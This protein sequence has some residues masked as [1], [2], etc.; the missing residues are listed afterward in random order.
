[1]FA[2]FFSGGSAV[3]AQTNISNYS[4]S[5]ATGTTYTP[6]TGGT[7]AFS[8]AYDNSVSAA[9]TM[10]GTFPFGG[11]N[12]TTC[13]ISTN[14]FI[15]FGAAAGTTNYTPMSTLGTTTGAIAAFAQDAAAST[16]V[17]AVP[18]I[19]Y[20]NTGT[21]FV[22]QFADHANYYNRTT[23]RLNFQIR[24][25]YATGA[26][27][28]VYGTC[29][30]PGTVST[31][32]TAPQVGIR[33]NSVAYATNVNS[34]YIGNVPAST[35]CD[36]SNAVSGFANSSA[37][38][39]SGTTN[40]NVKI[41]AGLKYTWTPA[42]QLPVRTFTA[43]TAIT[44]AG[45]TL[46]WTAPT[47]A[48]S[49]N[50]QYR[51]P[52]T[53]SW[54]S[55]SGN[56][57]TTNSVTL[58][59]LTQT[60]SYQVRVQASNG[61]SQ[62][63][64]SH[65]PNSAGTGDGYSATGTF[66]TT[67]PTPPSCIALPTS[68]ANAA[69]GIATKVLTWPAAS[70]GAAGY[71]LY[72]GTDASATNIYNGV[73]LG[74][75][76]TYTIPATLTVGTYYWKIVPYNVYGSSTGC[77]TW[78]Y[79]T[80]A[81][82]CS[83][84]PV[85][86]NAA[87]AIARN[88]TL[89]W[90]APSSPAAT[91]YDVYL[92]T[93]PSPSF[94]ANVTTTSY[95]PSLLTANTT[96]YWK[97]VSKNIFGDAVG[98]VE[99]S[100][101]TGTTILYCTPSY[102]FGK[103]SG[104][105]IANIVI[106][107]T[108][109]SNN[110]GTAAT[111]PA[112]TYFTGQPNYTTTLQAGSSYTVTV[113]IGSYG[114]QNIAAWIDYND[115]G[116]FETTERIGTT[117]SS[118]SGIATGNGTA[119]F[120][121][122]LAC[123][124]PLGT[125]RMR[126]RDV[127]LTSGTSIDPCASYG[128]GETEDYD[129]TIS[130]ANPCPQP[131]SL[132]LNTV[133]PISANLGWTLGCAETNWEVKVQAAGTGTPSVAPGTGVAVTTTSYAATG[134]NP[135]TNYEFYVR[136]TCTPGSLYSSWT[137]P[138]TFSTLLVAP[139]PYS[140]SFDTTTT[141]ADWSLTN[142]SI[143]AVA[144]LAPT[145]NAVSLNLWSSTP[146]GNISTVNIGP[147]L[148]GQY[149]TFD[150]R[151][152]DFA[153]GTT[154]VP[155]T[156]TGDYA[157]QIS[158][159]YG[160]TYTTLETVSN[161]GIA[162]WRNKLY[163]LS[164]YVGEYVKIRINATWVSGD[165]YLGFDNF[166]VGPICSGAPNGGTS[167]PISQ[168]VCPN[169][170]V[171]PFT[172]AGASNDI[173]IVYQWEQ[174]TDNGSSWSNVVGGSGATS[175]SYSPPIFTGTTIQ[176]RLKV[177]CTN[178]A[179]DSYS[180]VS[181]I[182]TNS[183]PL[184][185]AQPFTVISTLGGWTQS[186]GYGV[187]TARGATGNPGA[188][189]FSNLSSTTTTNTFTSAKYG[190]VLVG[191]TLSFDLK[192]S[193][194]VTPFGPPAAGWGTIDVQVSTDCGINYTTVGTINDTPTASY[195]NYKYYLGAFVGQGVTIRLTGNWLAG[196]YDVSI[197][198]WNIDI[199]A[200]QVTDLTPGALCSA[201]GGAITISGYAFNGTTGVTLGGVPVAFTLNSDVSITATI[202]PAATSGIIGVTTPLGTGYSSSS[203]TINPNPTVN[204]ITGGSGL[205]IGTPLVLASTTPGGVWASTNTAVATVLGGNVTGLSAGQTT[206]TYTV[207]DNGC[208]TTV[209]QLVDVRE[210]L[211]NVTSPLNVSALTGTNASFSSSAS[212]TG[213]SFVWQESLDGG[214]VYNDITIS[215][216]YSVSTS[217][218]GS[219]VT[220]T[221]T[222]ASVTSSDSPVGFNGRYYR[223]RILATSP[224]ADVSEESLGAASL[225]VGN[226]GIAQ[227]PVSNTPGICE[228]GSTSFSVVA[229][230]D[231]DAYHWYLDKNDGNPPV[232]I[233]DGST[234]DGITYAIS[235]FDVTPASFGNLNST[236]SLSGVSY[237]NG[238]NGY[239]YYVVVQG[240]AQSPSTQSTPAT[241][242]VSQGVSIP[243][244]GQPLSIT[245]CKPF[246]AATS[247]AVFTVAPSGSAGS[248]QWQTL[249]GSTWT[250]VG[251]LGA[252][253]TI[254]L[255]SSNSVGVTS[256][257]A[258]V[259]GQG[260]CAS[261]TS[262]V[263][264]LT[265]TQPTITVTPSSASYCTPG[266]PVSLTANGA[267]TYTWSPA[268][269]LSATSGATVTASP[270]VNTT[271]TVTG[272]DASGCINTT[273]VSI[274]VGNTVSAQATASLTSVCTGA[275]VQLDA[276]GDQLFTPSNIGAYTFTNTTSPFQSIV[277]GAGTVA[278]TLSGMDDS[279]S[280]AQTLPFT[281]NYGG[282]PF[283][284]FKINSNGWLSLGTAS[285]ATTNYN[286]LN[287]T[288]NNVIAAFNSDLNGN[289]TASTS[290]YVQTTGTAPNR[291]TKIE[292]VNVKNY[293]GTINP[294]TANFQVWLYES[295][296]V[297][298][299][300]Y[301]SFTSSSARTIAGSV[302]VGLRGATAASVNLR[303]LSNTG[304]WS[305]PTLSGSSTSSCALGT[306]ASPLLPDNGRVYRFA[307]GNTP[308]YTYAWSSVP[309]GFTS[310]LK[311]P[312]ANPMVST[313]YSVVVTSSITGCN[314]TAL[315]P[316]V[317]VVT[318]AVITTQP[319]ATSICEGGTTSLTVVATGPGLTYQWMLN[320]A[321]ITGA[322]SATYTITGATLAQS[323][324]YSVLVTPIC[325]TTATSTPVALVVNPTP[326]AT[327][328]SNVSYCLGDT[329]SS[330][331]LNGTP[332]GVVF[333]VTGGAAIG[334]SNLTGVTSIPSFTTTAAGSAT[335]VITPRANGCSGT[336]VT[337]IVTVNALPT[338]VTVTPATTTNC[339]NS[340][341][342]LLTATGGLVT[343]NVALGTGTTLNS[344]TG[345]PSPLSNYYGG[346]K[347]Q[348]LIQASELT[349]LGFVSGD[350]ITGI[351]FNVSA[352][353]S[354]FSGSLSSFRIEMGTTA[355]NALTSSSFET[356]STVVRTASTL[357]VPT[358]GLPADLVV[359]FTTNFTW[360]GS[361]NIV[362][363]TS[364]SNANTGLAT[365][366]VQSTNTDPGFVS[367]NYYYVDGG[368]VASVRNATTP[369]GSSNNRPNIKLA[370]L[371]TGAIT[372]TP[373]TGLYTDAA[374][375]TA[376]AGGN[377]ATVYA[378]PSATQTYTAKATSS[379]GC[380][381]TGSATINVDPLSVA[382]TA[383]ALASTV[384][385]GSGT[386]LTLNGSTGAIQWQSGASATG[387]WSNVS[388]ATSASLAT[389][390]LTA[391]TYYQAVVTSGVC[392]SATSNVVSV[393]VSPTSVA[394]TASGTST[395]CSGTGT[396]VSL[397]GNVGT[398][399]WQ[400]ASSA[401]GPWTNVSGGSS[402]TLATGN[403][404][405]TTYYQAVVTSGVCGSATSNVVTVTVNTNVTYYADADGDTY[406]NFAI[407]Q[408]SCSGAPV[409]YVSNSL[410]CD[411]TKASVR[412]GA[413][414]VCYDA[415]DNDCNGNVDNVGLP[416]GCI[417][418]VANLQSAS[419]GST[420]SAFNTIISAS[421]VPGA[422]AFRFKITN[423]TTNVVQIL[424]SPT[425]SFQ[426]MNLPG[427]T[428][429]TQY[430]VEVAIRFAG[431]WQGFYG[432]PCFVNTPSPVSVV[433]S[434]QCGGTLTSM[435][436][437]INSSF[438]S[439]VT[440]YRYEVTNQ[441]N[442]QTQYVFSS[443]NRFTLTQLLASNQ[444]FATNYFVRVACRN[445][446]GTYL[447]E[448]P[449][450]I[451]KS[452]AFPTTQVVSSLCNNYLVPSMVAPVTVDPVP[453]ATLYKF[454]LFNGTYDFVV[455]SIY[456]RFTLSMFPGLEQGT[457]YSVQA[458]AQVGGIFDTNVLGEQKWGKTCT[459]T[460]PNAARQTETAASTP[461][462]E[463][464][465]NNEFN[466][467]AYPNPFA[468]NFKLDVTTNSE[469]NLSVRVYDMLGK[470][471]E[472]RKVNATDVETLEVGANYPSGVYNVIVTQGEN[473]KTLRVIK[474]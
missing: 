148:A 103:T 98:C 10:G 11:S 423:M 131:S 312:I 12:F 85:P 353:G 82:N 307:P 452:P 191:H 152:I 333:D 372:W 138:F 212:G 341:P 42:T 66:T 199:P 276:S 80:A 105:L 109:L 135:S 170:P 181:E 332:S 445:T 292:W 396:T 474:R 274:V 394:G 323:G 163:N 54:T 6:I 414:D 34:L 317:N 366:F 299:I 68:P 400:Q 453:G 256:Y 58:T 60:T 130:A 264:T 2:C 377:S 25:T 15:T 398:I 358:T 297:V 197:D 355:S 471:V 235:A 123:N 451:V 223:A 93:S 448:G 221:L 128:Y 305:T 443:I 37:M 7:T 201:S 381:R 240:P 20:V 46:S 248:I 336:P 119:S 228:S 204:A 43:P 331:T 304:S 306:F 258:I 363:Q 214:T 145:T 362:I 470:L 365:D 432:T 126:V 14:G 149:L 158:K 335:I 300:R 252:S 32:G 40:V 140:Q 385:Y 101:T 262:D 211:A 311:N 57:V 430:K 407:T 120:G 26:I 410:D 434:A 270:L 326:T 196:S 389:G 427:V 260:S 173:G 86:A 356:V 357:T 95:A 328:P 195:K 107:G 99:Q 374:G 369:L 21:E 226:T 318:D 340:S 308:S 409:G 384:C 245:T 376:Y 127:W 62:S 160:A 309:A 232:E 379:A 250:N 468:A 35:T 303:S 213:V 412:P 275:S 154:T 194:F 444:T 266:S 65:I 288:E 112:Y 79:T 189:A 114:S 50:V 104:D 322:N 338:A 180:S 408:I 380:I 290:Y 157:V 207:T 162:G 254:N 433:S 267:S 447:P 203:L 334:L 418:K 224:C 47:G 39:F 31:T 360:D 218:S 64:Y 3:F 174:S 241:L 316:T 230:G 53:C 183:N 18:L 319:I 431:V 136:A 373:S 78:S 269:G 282:T 440:G 67:A 278:V 283:T 239:L 147:V 167:S 259:N 13:F 246:G 192:I 179:T 81:P 30:N 133:S 56:P 225:S 96:Y 350:K 415:I 280:A 121:I 351:T 89:S 150:Y 217:T 359:P 284:G 106:N 84:V 146:S 33:G 49:Y 55:W 421:N 402:A 28:I 184:P 4:F 265:I 469:E 455:E 229:S 337:Y 387:P 296:Y 186:G 155:G 5:T 44:A 405:A 141:P 208:P 73:D 441:T 237:A 465:V 406:G 416:G 437:N 185:L 301:G 244:S 397:N 193:N 72:Y 330:L 287:G 327:A 200:P 139:T 159:D 182:N 446:D 383:S 324:N 349:S 108:S 22:V 273:T 364:Y 354:T 315:T 295:S 472:D 466:A 198:N 467:L 117:G 205:C 371:S 251:S 220:S 29:T 87:T 75:V 399:Q 253:L 424:D 69:T 45:A 298:E 457:L 176:Y 215:A 71:T 23:E 142:F 115:N 88:P 177:T 346:T 38:L 164:S 92:G 110:S 463:V 429:A 367:T 234:A 190:P 202:P 435:S 169:L 285:T 391:D 404:T 449:G 94:V 91:S 238:V 76:T 90:T 137:G 129:V 165:Y 242:N 206:I 401:S 460:T 249:V 102:T 343:S 52:G 403:L 422:Q 36:W 172:V 344:T 352:V 243:T 345:Y 8:G 171:Q 286:A 1:M 320:G 124:P 122:S 187:G 413:V 390:N 420:V 255:S 9:I 219:I 231:V 27:N 458:A 48:T 51:I 151:L 325:G 210:P 227:I 439:N 347:H 222:I 302:Q 473:T 144:N 19:S 125:H 17:G 77:A 111:N 386:S 156:G 329:T 272:T 459:L 268:A 178:S 378:R 462:L 370:R 118:T 289:N 461:R 175:L 368:T 425:I 263:V 313:T 271:Y 419:C 438:V 375:T 293:D 281:F 188:N 166:K 153:A 464:V 395:I 454:R 233:L 209:S 261:V 294:E 339:V 411:D 426:F 74:N 70:G 291:I 392:S 342:I 216:P 113:T 257:R 450:C 442:G 348:M 321:N 97:V 132:A 310:T 247:T 59:G 279:I 161:D 24:L 134:L 61:T 16:V 436:Q 314:A 100:F 116:T 83:T 63:I 456:N 393:S 428:F 41:P 277:G 388:G 168:S 382:G 143:G 417:P 236:L 361:S